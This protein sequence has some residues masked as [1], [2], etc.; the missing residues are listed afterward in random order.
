MSRLGSYKN[1]TFN[2]SQKFLVLDPSTSSASLVLA[3]ELV[4]Y[5]TPSLNSVKAESTRL[6]AENTDYKV[7]ELVQTSGATAIGDGLASVYLVVAGGD[8]D[9]PMLNGNDLLVL[10][11]D[12]ALRAQLISEVAGQGASL[13]SMQGGPTVEAAVTAA[14]AAILNR[15]IRVSSRTEMKTYDVPAGY[16]FSLSEGGRSGMFVVVDGSIPTVDPEEGIYVYFSAAKYFAR[17]DIGTVDPVM[18]G[19]NCN[20]VFNNAVAVQ[21]CFDFL[22]VHLE[23]DIYTLNLAGEISV[24]STVT[25]DTPKIQGINASCNIISTFPTS[26][27][28][29]VFK[30]IGYPAKTV[31]GTLAITGTG[32]ATFSNRTNTSLLLVQNSSRIA[33]D[34]LRLSF[35]KQYGVDWLSTNLPSVQTFISNYNGCTPV[36]GS[37]SLNYAFSSRADTGSSGSTAQST[38]LTLSGAPDLEPQLGVFS[39]VR[40]GSDLH[41]IRSIDNTAKTITVYPWVDLTVTSGTA[42]CISGSGMGFQGGDGGQAAWVGLWD[43]TGN[44]VGYHATLLYPPIVG[45]FVSQSCGV[46]VLISQ[47]SNAS[48]GGSLQKAYFE[49]NLFDIVQG[50]TAQA[51]FEMLGETAISLDT[52]L[53]VAPLLSSNVGSPAFIKLS[54]VSLFLNGRSYPGTTRINH[55][56]ITSSGGPTSATINLNDYTIDPDISRLFGLTAVSFNVINSSAGNVGSVTVNPVTGGTV[57]G[58]ATATYT[59]VTGKILTID[60]YISASDS[61]VNFVG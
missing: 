17:E 21:A 42:E 58:G 56:I 8:G 53:K 32:G 40:I 37:L 52:C 7:G 49:V 13:V 31:N 55:T 51:K 25:L 3:S 15:V 39:W 16:K 57:N 11:G 14:E 24:G 6:S 29:Y 45:S 34:T 5:I 50:T 23:G 38:V 33:F 47:G 10:I 26:L 20:G 12:D 19:A 61:L 46:G 41:Y 22:K 4:A 2:E 18:W 27:G 44:G 35:A 60:A 30:I 36:A 43:A 28:Q 1:T 54:G 59:A 48:V 9:F